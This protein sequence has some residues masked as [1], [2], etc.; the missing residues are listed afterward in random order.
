[1]EFLKKKFE[2]QL[3]VLVFFKLYLNVC[4]WMNEIG[5]D[6]NVYDVIQGNVQSGEVFVNCL[7]YDWD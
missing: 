4:I 5:I 1:M 6:L 2:F 7:V 3:G